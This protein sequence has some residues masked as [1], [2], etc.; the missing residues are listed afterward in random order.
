MCKAKDVREVDGDYE[1][2]GYRYRCETGKVFRL[3]DDPDGFGGKVFIF[4]GN[5]LGQGP[6]AAIARIHDAFMRADA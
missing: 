3:R 4:C 1:I 2:D 5:R 6:R